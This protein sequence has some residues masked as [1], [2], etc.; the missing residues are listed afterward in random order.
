[1]G[2]VAGASEL[3]VPPLVVEAADD[4]VLE[5]LDEPPPPQP[6]TSRTRSAKRTS[7]MADLG[8]SFLTIDG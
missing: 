6:A 5:E 4:E 2:T 8:F 7:G 1:M 3:V